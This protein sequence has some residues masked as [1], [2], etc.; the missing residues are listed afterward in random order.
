MA[1]IRWQRISVCMNWFQNEMYD[2]E[3]TIAIGLHQH[4]F[5][6]LQSF[7]RST[8]LKKSFLDGDNNSYNIINHIDWL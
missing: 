5:E 7:T 4:T 2:N 1:P 8:G 3:L 6:L